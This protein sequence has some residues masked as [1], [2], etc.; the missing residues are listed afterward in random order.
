[1][2][3]SAIV[4]LMLWAGSSVGQA[5][6]VSES[7][8]AVALTVSAEKPYE[9]MA[10]ESKRPA[11]SVQCSMKGKK[12]MHLVTFSAMGALATE[13]PENAPKNGEITL[14]VAM[15]GAKQSTEWIPY[16]DTVTFAYY[17]KTEPER[18]KFLQL[19]MNAPTVSIE[20]TPF[21][22]GTPITSVFDL[23][24]LHEEVM[25]RAECMMK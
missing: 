11:L 20:F 16:G 14:N 1:M 4:T 21:L 12:T 19:L 10:G 6:H 22:T 18:V 23:S 25:N 5:V 13:D 7:K 17:G 8:G 3:W 24:K 15:D 2:N 9:I